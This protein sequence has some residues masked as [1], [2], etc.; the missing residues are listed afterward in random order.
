MTIAERI[1]NGVQGEV[2][3]ITDALAIVNDGKGS[4][5]VRYITS[6]GELKKKPVVILDHDI[7]AG[8]F[9]SAAVQKELIEFA[10]KYELEFIQSQG[11]GYQIIFDRKDVSSEIIV[12]SGTHNGFFGAD[13]KVGLHLAPESLAD[14]LMKGSFSI[15]IPEVL[16]IELHGTLTSKITAS[17]AVYTMLKE[18]GEAGI[19]GKFIQFSGDGST[20]L[21]TE[22]K[23][24]LGATM[25]QAG[26]FSALFSHEDIENIETV[27]F[28]L[29]GVQQVI[30]SPGSIFN[31]KPRNEFTGE[32]VSAVFLGGCNSGRIQDLKVLA[33]KVRGKRIQRGVRVSVGFSSN[34]EYL[35][36]AEEGY[37]EIF[38]DAGIQVLN[39]GCGSCRTTS[40][41]VVGDDEVLL[42]TGSYNDAGCAGTSLSY[43][44]IASV[45]TISDAALSGLM[46]SN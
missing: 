3:E 13:G 46:A 19:A 29:S 16:V 36:A 34:S 22:D 10:Q 8:S 35:K 18:L 1:F 20:G 17:D 45:E 24:V 25:T 15:V 37:I 6:D 33:R 5:A 32:K 31:A 14:Y 9:A 21:S 27:P 42:T 44:Y 41:G 11:I 30:V 23:I 7:P 39:P 2:A 40:I 28:D 4:E 38:L 26:A 43:V 12:S